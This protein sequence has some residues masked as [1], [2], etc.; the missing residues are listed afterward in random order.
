M[1]NEINYHDLFDSLD[2]LNNL[3][4]NNGDSSLRT[5]LKNKIIGMFGSPG[6][7]TTINGP[8][9]P[10]VFTVGDG[11]ILVGSERLDLN[12]GR[13]RHRFMKIIWN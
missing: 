4:L 1:E 5:G 11:I 2:E 3:I 13:G 12:G 6:T 7:L 9:L 8:E 10:A